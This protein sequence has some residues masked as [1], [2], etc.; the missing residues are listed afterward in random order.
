MVDYKKLAAELLERRAAAAQPYPFNLRDDVVYLVHGPKW[1]EIDKQYHGYA[2]EAR[3]VYNGEVL[4]D[5]F[6]HY[7]AALT[8]VTAC[9]GA[10]NVTYIDLRK[11]PWSRHAV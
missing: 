11:A 7:V 4:A 5:D 3:V 9:F 10:E 6:P 1:I 2:P 8:Y